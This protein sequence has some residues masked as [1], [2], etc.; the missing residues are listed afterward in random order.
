[1][2]SRAW[3]AIAC[4][5]SALAARRPRCVSVLA[6]SAVIAQELGSVA[7]AAP[8][9][10]PP[11]Q[12]QPK[13]GPVC[14]KVAIIGDIPPPP[15][16]KLQIT[17]GGVAAPDV[18]YKQIQ[19]GFPPHL[20]A[21]LVATV[22][23]LASTGPITVGI[24]RKTAFGSPGVTEKFTLKGAF[25][26]TGSKI[27]QPT[28]NSFTAAPT[29][30][31]PQSGGSK[32]SWSITGKTTAL[33]LNGNAIIALGHHY[34]TSMQ[35]DAN[36][37]TSYELIAGNGC[38][39]VARQLTLT[40]LPPLSITVTPKSLTLLPGQ[41][42]GVEV[43]IPRKTVP[44]TISCDAICTPLVVNPTGSTP[45]PQ[46]FYIQ[47][48][49]VGQGL[50]HVTATLQNPSMTHASAPVTVNTPIKEGY[51]LGPLQFATATIPAT[52]GFTGCQAS[53]NQGSDPSSWSTIFK[54]GGNSSPL[55][56]FHVYNQGSTVGGVATDNGWLFAVEDVPSPPA[57]STS[58]QVNYRVYELP[59]QLLGG[60]HSLP[61][62]MTFVNNKTITNMP[63]FWY[64]PDGSIGL[65]RQDLH[66]FMNGY[67][68]SFTFY[69]LYSGASLGTGYL[70]GQFKAEVK[71]GGATVE[72]TA[73]TVTGNGGPCA[74]PATN[75]MAFAINK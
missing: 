40:V 30:I 20:S 64:S 60:D 65:I 5:S 29:V 22:P 38:L 10:A 33:A 13:S 55:I 9:G 37:T 74:Q 54:C 35:I 67:M 70:T 58:G 41:G 12:F 21:A 57:N 72:F 69:D 27:P 26:V 24:V 18:Q 15:Y 17:I 7:I 51:F 25:V 52:T 68:Q 48:F 16:S 19:T 14:S 11:P 2:A 32:L 1:M 39:S 66:P 4:T 47:P 61:S 75:C 28:F 73:G 31:D 62:V 42:S 44:V 50:I 63:D 71:S 45:P 49:A 56:P 23:G 34:P 6:L 53:V 36:V 43:S 59:Y 8:P 46:N 3:L